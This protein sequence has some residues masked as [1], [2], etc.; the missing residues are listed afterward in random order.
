MSIKPIHKET[1]KNI[2]IKANPSFEH[3]KNHHILPLTIHEF[4]YAAQ[5]F[6]IVFVKDQETGQFRV[7]AVVGLVPEE[8]IFYSESGWLASYVPASLKSYPFLATS[9]GDGSDQIV[10]CI[11]EDSDLVNEKEGEALFDEEGNQTEFIKAKGQ[12]LAEMLERNRQTDL[13]IKH[14][15]SKDLIMPR[16]LTIQFKD[17]EPYELSGMYII[18][19]AKLNDMSDEEFCDLRKLGYLAPI[20]ASLLSLSRVNY[21]AKQKAAKAAA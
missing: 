10:I 15:T 16:K 20:Y 19:E 4:S 9:A 6:P 3:S 12:F 17:E 7:V 5:E 11:N 1:H 13:F 21:L 8:N 18:D 14:L 2:K